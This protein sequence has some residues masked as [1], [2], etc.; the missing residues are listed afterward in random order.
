VIPSAV[1]R[2]FLTFD[3]NCPCSS[4][5]SIKGVWIQS[6]S[7]STLKL[8]QNFINVFLTGFG[9]ISHFNFEKQY[10]STNIQNRL[11]TKHQILSLQIKNL[12]DLVHDRKLSLNSLMTKA[13]TVKTNDKEIL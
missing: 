3:L 5:F 2:A 4:Y 12:C 9:M 10:S 7:E 8:E 1:S 6:G 13:I 11:S